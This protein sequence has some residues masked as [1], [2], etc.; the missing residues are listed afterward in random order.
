V[1]S[2]FSFVGRIMYMLPVIA[3]A[4]MMK[5]DSYA[6]VNAAVYSGA[7][8]NLQLCIL[9]AL[10]SNSYLESGYCMTFISSKSNIL[11]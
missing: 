9:E 5:N 8:N 11:C 2:W 4:W 10:G 6:L 3:M 7:M 1:I